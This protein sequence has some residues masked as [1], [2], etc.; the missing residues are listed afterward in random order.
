MKFNLEETVRG[1]ELCAGF[2]LLSVPRDQFVLL[3]QYLEESS[4][5]P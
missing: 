5:P 4:L 3:L 1:A 2:S